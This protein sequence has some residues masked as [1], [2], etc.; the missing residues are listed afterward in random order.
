[1]T[2]N[3]VADVEILFAAVLCVSGPTTGTHDIHHFGA[4]R[5]TLSL[6]Q[7]PAGRKWTHNIYLPHPPTKVVVVVIEEEEEDGLAP[8]YI[9]T[10]LSL[11]GLEA[12]LAKRKKKKKS[13]GLGIL[14]SR[15]SISFLERKTALDFDCPDKK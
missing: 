5:L 12:R 7:Q 11:T 4:V 10:T 15:R 9:R 1:M 3:V 2:E 8:I 14:A 13:Q 6:S